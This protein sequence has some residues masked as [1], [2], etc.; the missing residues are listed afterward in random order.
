MRDGDGSAAHRTLGLFA[1]D[2][3]MCVSCWKWEAVQCVVVLE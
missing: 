1:A 2:E 3:V